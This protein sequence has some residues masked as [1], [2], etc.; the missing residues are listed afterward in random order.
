MQITT[1]TT[2]RASVFFTFELRGRWT[3]AAVWSPK[4]FE[5]DISAVLNGWREWMK[6]GDLSNGGWFYLN[7]VPD[8]KLELSNFKGPP[9]TATP[10]CAFTLKNRSAGSGS[11]LQSSKTLQVR[12]IDLRKLHRDEQTPEPLYQQIHWRN[13]PSI[14]ARST[15]YYSNSNQISSIVQRHRN[16]SIGMSTFQ[17]APAIHL[18][19]A[20]VCTDILIQIQIIYK[21]QAW[22]SFHAHNTHCERWDKTV[23]IF[24]RIRRWGLT[25]CGGISTLQSN[26]WQLSS[27]SS[28]STFERSALTPSMLSGAYTIISVRNKKRSK[29]GRRKR[30]TRW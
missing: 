12:H 19:A 13:R 8:L 10:E 17:F 20:L 1:I 29:I 4:I 24:G 27:K 11:A 30:S 26:K 21:E 15:A 7:W 16:T 18:I 28:S 23:L 2:S 14:I 5:S 22:T 6:G 9:P 3:S 25:I